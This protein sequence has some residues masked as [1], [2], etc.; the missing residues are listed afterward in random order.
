[1]MRALAGLIYLFVANHAYAGCA[2]YEDGSMSGPAPIYKICYKA[3]C[4][5]T[6]MA[7]ECANVFNYSVAYTIGWS[8]HCDAPPEGGEGDCSIFWQ[9]RP[10]DPGKYKYVSFKMISE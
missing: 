4:D 5:I 9:G 7:Y 3:Q 10:I 2:N 6:T 1:M 8:I